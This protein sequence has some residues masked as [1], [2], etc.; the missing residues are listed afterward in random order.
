MKLVSF[1]ETK[2]FQLNRSRKSRFHKACYETVA[3][4]GNISVPEHIYVI[5]Q[6]ELGGITIPSN[7]NPH[8]Q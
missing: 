2:C 3:L 6:Y 8:K 5:K 7:G 1:P 4:E